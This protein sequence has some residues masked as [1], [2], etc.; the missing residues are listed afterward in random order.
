MQAPPAPVAPAPAP[1]V[2][3]PAE[4]PP[5][6]PQCLQGSWS[7]DLSTLGA[8]VAATNPNP[9]TVVASANVLN[10]I[11]TTFTWEARY[12]VEQLGAAP[13]GTV[14]MPEVV[15]QTDVYWLQSGE[16]LVDAA[17]VSFVAT[18][19]SSSMPATRVFI[20]G[21]WMSFPGSG[22][23]V[24]PLLGAVPVS[25]A[26]ERLQ[27]YLPLSAAGMAAVLTFDRYRPS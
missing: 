17:T 14:P 26:A 8:I 20:D 21:A 27:L 18:V 3:M 13:P 15:S 12:T 23:P 24:V 2:P 16:L 22:E 19:Q 11:G 7:A 4:L 25:C 5:V 9:H 10:V 1:I 6:D